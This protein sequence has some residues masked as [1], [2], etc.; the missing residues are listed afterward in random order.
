MKNFDIWNVKP[1][2]GFD[3]VLSKIEFIQ[4]REIGESL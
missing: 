2:K 3:F 1:C 4:L